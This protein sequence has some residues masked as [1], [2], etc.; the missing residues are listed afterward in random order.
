MKYL[1]DHNYTPITVTQ[2]AKIIAKK[3]P[4][5]LPER[6]VI[7]TFDDGFADFYTEALPVLA[8][9]GFAATLYITTGFIEDKIRLML[10]WPQIIDISVSGIEC[11]AHSHT[12]P[13]LDT[14]SSAAAWDEIIRCK[15]ILEQKLGRQVPSFAYPYGYHNEAV[16]Q[17]V[18]QA[19]YSSAC[20]VKHAMSTVTDDCFALA[21][22]MVT[23][24]TDIEELDSFL[25]G[26]VLSL[27][28]PRER[29][30]TVMWR[31]LRRRVRLV[32]HTLSLD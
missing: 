11:G 7:L 24:D 20:A 3:N 16:R 25:A 26:Q 17:M 18:Q 30:Q 29:M 9:Y 6:A 4:A 15:R 5:Q 31:F 19:G 10:T 32:K 23:A 27:A 21:R 13:Q 12:H 1:R 22:I 28:P 2:L 8:N 14:L